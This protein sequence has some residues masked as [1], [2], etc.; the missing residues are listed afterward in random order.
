M[1]DLLGSLQGFIAI[2]KRSKVG[3]SEVFG[4]ARA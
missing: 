2:S 3:D 1:K 4:A